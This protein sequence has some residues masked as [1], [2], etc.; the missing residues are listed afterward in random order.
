MHQRARPSTGHSLRISRRTTHQHAS[1]TILAEMPASQACGPVYWRHAARIGRPPSTRAKRHKISD[2]GSVGSCVWAR[3]ML[4]PERIRQRRWLPG[5]RPFGTS[6]AQHPTSPIPVVS[7]RKIADLA[8][9]ATTRNRG[10]ATAFP[11]ADRSCARCLRLS[12]S[13]FFARRGPELG[14]KGTEFVLLRCC[15]YQWRRW[16]SN[17]RPRS[18]KGGVYE[19]SR[20]SGLV[21]RSPRR[22]G[23]A[24]PACC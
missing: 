13:R 17:P 10:V 16:E 5:T 21:P 8:T 20:R 12:S 14:C 22:R 1:G 24:G 4:A 3:V 19:R 9:R 11:V 23:C 6:P 7:G 2:S 18:R 15:P